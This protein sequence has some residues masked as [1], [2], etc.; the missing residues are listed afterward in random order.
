MGSMLAKD[1]VRIRLSSTSDGML[2]HLTVNLLKL[3][4]EALL[5]AERGTGTGM[6]FAEFAY[7]LLQ[8]VDWVELVTRHNCLLQVIF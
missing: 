3:L 6:S 5:F 7:P 4:M 8:A 1:N 2:L